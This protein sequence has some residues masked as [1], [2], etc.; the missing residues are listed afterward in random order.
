M[1]ELTYLI[2]PLTG[3][4]DVNAAADKVRA[5]ITG[6]LGGEIK[7]EYIS[8][9]KR[10]GFSI[11]KQSSGSYATVEF[12]AEP[13]KISDLKKFLELNSD[14]LRH[15]ILTLKEGRPAKQRPARV[16]PVATALPA[17]ELS[18][19]GEKVKIEDLDKKLEELLK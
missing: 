12:A 19:K 15:L 8:E 17:E 18:H 5:F 3:D 9:K 7:K 2:S 16:K 14:V 10:L 11:K 6:N 13:E 4:L 1:Y